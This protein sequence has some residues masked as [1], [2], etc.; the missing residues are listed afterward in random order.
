MLHNCP[1]IEVPRRKART[2][3]PTGV[4]TV[5]RTFD[6][7]GVFMPTF[8]YEKALSGWYENKSEQPNFKR[9]D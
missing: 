5:G 7:V 2:D 3:V 6:D 4:H 8:G 9:S 1:V